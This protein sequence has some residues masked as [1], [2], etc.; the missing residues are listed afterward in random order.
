ME[1]LVFAKRIIERTASGDAWTG[2]SA[3]CDILCALPDRERITATSLPSRTSLQQLLWDKV[4]IVRS[5]LELTV[6]AQV[7]AGWQAAL[8]EP[9]D[10]PT[11]ELHNLIVTARL[12]TEAAL[13]REESRGA[14]YCTDFPQALESWRKHIVISMENNG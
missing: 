7:L 5:G 6:A 11:W 13:V 4:G 1:V 3:P 8:P 2:I 12:M 9:C 14:H 10:R